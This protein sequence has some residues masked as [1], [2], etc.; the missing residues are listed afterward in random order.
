[1]TAAAAAKVAERVVKIVGLNGDC[2][3]AVGHS[4]KSHEANFVYV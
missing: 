4:E 3:W 2:G 1:M